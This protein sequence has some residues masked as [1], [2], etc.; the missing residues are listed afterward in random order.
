MCSVRLSLVAAAVEAGERTDTGLVEQLPRQ[1]AC[2]RLDLGLELALLDGQSLDPPGESAQR[3]QRPSELRVLTAF[4]AGR[5]QSPEQLG[6]GQRA[7]LRPQRLG[8]RDEE[9]AQLAE[10]GPPGG[11]RGFASSAQR[12]Q[13]FSL[14]SGPRPCWSRLAE[15]APSGP[16]R[17]ERVA[18]AGLPPPSQPAD[19]E[20]PL[21]LAA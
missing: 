14:A 17:V 1:L 20:H 12:P 11:H 4:G 10:P 6:S 21:A 7:E 8:R 5:G 16:D 3:E 9:A 18:L 2:Q 13:R 15:Q 19:L